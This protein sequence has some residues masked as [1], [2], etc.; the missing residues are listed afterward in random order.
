MRKSKFSETQIVAMLKDAESGVW[1][2]LPRKHSVAVAPL[3]RS[4]STSQPC[5][6]VEPARHSVPTDAVLVH[7]PSLMNVREGCPP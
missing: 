3:L 5:E 4:R 1:A 2:D 6:T 7:H